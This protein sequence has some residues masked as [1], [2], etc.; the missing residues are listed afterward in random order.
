MKILR[1]AVHNIASLAGTHTVD[2]TKEPLR[3]AG[4]YSISGATGA[5]KST[6]L[7]ALCLALYNKTPR[8]QGIGA[9]DA[10][11]SG[12]K[13][14]DTRSLLRRGSVEAFAEVS[15]VGI[16]QQTWTARW[17][18]R[19]SYRR[20]DGSL[21]DVEM[22][23]YRGQKEL[24][25]QCK[26]EL[27]GRLKVV[28][29]AIEQKIGLTFEQFTRAVLLAQNDFAAFLKADDRQRAEILQA[30][31]G[32]E[33]FEK[34]SQE[35][36][37]RSAE[38]K[39]R[40]ELIDTQLT[41]N[42]PLSDDERVV[43]KTAIQ[44]AQ[45]Q[46]NQS[47]VALK[48]YESFLEWFRIRT[49]RESNVQK[50]NQ[51]LLD[52]TRRQT[53]SATQRSELHSTEL[54]AREAK[55]LRA[56][57]E[58]A[59]QSVR[60][61][62]IAK[63]EAL[64]QV[65]N[66]DSELAILIK[67]I[68]K[69]SQSLEQIKREQ[70]D[71]E[72]AL[73]KARCLDTLLVPA[74]KYFDKSLIS[75]DAARVLQLAA[76]SKHEEAKL[77]Q[78]V[79]IARQAEL[80]ITK[81]SLQSWAP[82]AKQASTW[83]DR[84]DLAI[85]GK[86]AIDT[87]LQAL[88]ATR[89]SFVDSEKS[90]RAVRLS[91]DESENAF[92]AADNLLQKAIVSE[93]KFYPE[94][95]AS[96]R[97][98]LESTLQA[99]SDLKIKLG[100]ISKQQ[101]KL[102]GMNADL[103]RLTLAQSQDRIAYDNLIE[104]ELPEAV[105][106]AQVSLQQLEAIQ[107]A[108]D[109]HAKR[110]RLALQ[111]GKECPVCGALEHP[112][113]EHAPDADATAVKAAKKSVK[114]FEKQRDLL[115]SKALELN[116]NIQN[117]EQQILKC[118][119]DIQQTTAS[120][121]SISAED[122]DLEEV[123]AI[124]ELPSNDD[125]LNV[126]A[127]LFTKTKN[128]LEQITATEKTCRDAMKT[129]AD[130][131]AAVEVARKLANETRQSFS[132]CEKHHAVIDQQQSQANAIW[133]QSKSN[134]ADL[135]KRLDEVWVL[136]PDLQIDFD[137][138]SIAA[139]EQFATK[140]N[141]FNLI[142]DQLKQCGSQLQ[143]IATEIGP[144][145]ESLRHV[146]KEISRCELDYQS[147]KAELDRHKIERLQIFGG[148]S[149]TEIESKMFAK[150]EAIEK[151]L[152]GLTSS[153][154]D[155]EKQLASAKTNLESATLASSQAEDSLQ[156][157][158]VALDAWLAKFATQTSRLVSL[159][160]LDDV[161][162]RDDSWIQ[163][164]RQSLKDVDDA[165]VNAQGALDVYLLQMKTHLETQPTEELESIIVDA[166]NLERTNH[167]QTKDSLEAAR[168]VLLNDDQR[169]AKNA[170]LLNQLQDQRNAAQ[171]WIQLNEVIGSADGAKFRVIA[172]R[173]TLD[174]LLRYANHQL[175]QLAIRYRLERLPE[176]LNLIVIDCDMEDERRS[177]HSLSGG[178]SFL[179]SL[180]LA[181]G[182]ASLTSNRVRIESL[183]IDEGFG[184]LDP[185]TLNTAMGALMQLECQGRKVGVISHVAEMSD[186]IPVQVKVIKGRGGKSTIEIPGLTT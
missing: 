52:A 148:E 109:D 151:E 146:E 67:K 61:K 49:E 127:A 66:I 17:S 62:T 166:A 163:E 73:T 136:L 173:K 12:E 100:E 140:V 58:I 47:T 118:Q 164:Q 144:L 182:L 82:L 44:V 10:L 123:R 141:A 72:P 152:L 170:G 85:D 24:E 115:Q 35:I 122:F 175:R 102:S 155:W 5:G 149:A 104:K 80:E 124:L 6:L 77:R 176:S 103:Q 51:Q 78:S 157:T 159:S 138:D 128:A 156:Q 107:L 95:L 183:F 28:L 11:S 48:K 32:T 27:A 68:Q 53:A 130:C 23:L 172:Q 36:H 79:L 50:A 59:I 9:L 110:L 178:E 16:D 76:K 94:R 135:V 139:R 180:A 137:R 14:K 145:E 131:R 93:N 126:A 105:I 160:E 34:I 174:V 114:Q 45:E 20:V 22:S 134:Y 81:S 184:S 7:D 96:D 15:F 171:P 179:V 185:A 74:T 55:P 132:D 119:S 64:E 186:L 165:V 92:R 21:Q 112:Y 70:I 39:K 90:I 31:T 33:L 40:Y 3:S 97:S 147:A 113:S 18:V 161:L 111:D 88:E 46:L 150:R 99:T 86:T 87:A 29:Q 4:L 116:V 43:A 158:Q 54:I 89:I 8:L 168:L 30:L 162:A 83:L 121:E 120:S 101:Q 154:N 57:H 19:R 71:L 181:L 153:N 1:I 143:K 177:I 169:I 129:T 63:K 117:R 91:K 41:G 106:A 84:M 108:I 26:P 42:P 2:F 125:R 37:R 25:S 65:Q 60:I 69:A 142:D 133:L 56:A 98:L 167:Q 13:Q 38:E 75:L